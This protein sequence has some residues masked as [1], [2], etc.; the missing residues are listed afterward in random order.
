LGDS[1]GKSWAW[2]EGNYFI[3]GPQSGS[4]PF[5]RANQNFQLYHRNDFIDGNKDSV[6]NGEAAG[7]SNYGNAKFLSSL[8]DL[9]AL[10]QPKP[11]VAPD[12]IYSANDALARAI[13]QVGAMPHGRSAVDVFMVD[14][15]LSYGKRGKH[16]TD[17]RDNGIYNNVGVLSAGEGWADA[18]NDGMPDH[19][20]DA[21]GLNK[22]D[23]GDAVQLAASGYL[24]I[25]CYVNSIEGAVKPYLRAPSKLTMADRTKSSITLAWTNNAVGANAIQLQRSTNGTDFTTIAEVAANVS[26][27]TVIGLEEESYYSFRLITTGAG[28][29]SSTPSEVLRVATV[30]D[31]KAPQQSINPSPARGATSRFYTEVGFFWE[32]E[33]GTWGGDIAY[34]VYFG[35]TPDGLTKLNAAALSSPTYTY[36]PATPLTMN[37]TCYWRVDATN[38]LGTT[39]GTVWTFKAGVNSFTTSYVDLGTDFVGAAGVGKAVPAQSGVLTTGDNGKAMSSP[40]TIY[41][42]TADEFKFTHNGMTISSSN[43]NVYGSGIRLSC[44]YLDNDADYL[45]GELT[46]NSGAKNIVSVTLNGTSANLGDNDQALP[47]VVFSDVFPFNA[48]RVIGAEDVEL[49]QCRKGESSKTVLAPVGAKSFRVYRKVTISV[50]DDTYSKIGAGA[51]AQDYGKSVNVRLAYVGVT[52]ELLS[53]DG[54]DNGVPAAALSDNNR[55]ATMSI[56]GVAA[57][58]NHEAGSITCELPSSVGSLGDF[59][60]EFTL[61]HADAKSNFTNGSSHN[62]AAGDL[63]FVVTAQDNTRKEYAAK[64][65]ISGQLSAVNTITYMTVNGVEAQLNQATGVAICDLS[66]S[67][68]S[69]GL[70]T[71]SYVL[72]DSKAVADFANNSQ[73][74]F[75][76]GSLTIEVS[77]ENGSKKT[78]TVRALAEGSTLSGVNTLSALK[79]DSIAAQIDQATGE[80]S[81]T[82]PYT[83]DTLGT[84]VVSFTL[85]DTL[86]TASFA[87]GSTHSFAQG[88]LHIVVTAEDGSTKTYTLTLRRAPSSVNTIASLQVNYID[89]DA[90]GDSL[91]C[92]LV[93][94]L[95]NYEVRFYLSD[96]R[97]T[98]DFTSGETH[99]FVA[100]NPL[101]IVV[102]AENGAQRTYVVLVK[103]HT[104]TAAGKLEA[105]NL[106]YAN[107]T[108]HNPDA[109]P[110]S[111]YSA[112]GATVLRDSEQT[113]ISLSHLPAGIYIARTQ[114]G[115]TVK[116]VR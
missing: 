26:S 37:S 78:Y 102:T 14:E 89:A 116:F 43:N 69:L 103:K 35:A 30:G 90:K 105:L 42:E 53:K 62:F 79:V 6:L 11:F 72:G 108:L 95:G 71:V 76:G 15:L 17:E 20:E 87:S 18:D 75:A 93:E 82:L 19:W 77:A 92:T 12:T 99:D 4:N 73:H 106:W 40:I 74:D 13:A 96:A 88:A 55:V 31:P 98:A 1:E 60:V 97:A 86:A 3:A 83:A 115:K 21:N 10:S 2:L 81:C 22:N 52:L 109:E 7:D 65:S 101:L 85:D 23:A 27:Y 66:A 91:I 25:E 59:P 33:T 34:D 64:V 44:L 110:L 47:V 5:T 51:G 80:A 41:G 68:E 50:V 38:S 45:T 94:G 39:S 63:S 56:N 70:F 100:Q 16:I 24:N 46:A 61:E 84:F 114:S 107:G 67:V 28:L 29:P 9:A 57:Q 113:A 58:V 49:P 48:S 111:I 54:E 32:N 104:P 8:A 36:V 112:A